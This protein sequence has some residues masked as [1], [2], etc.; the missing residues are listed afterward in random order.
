VQEMSVFRSPPPTCQGQWKGGTLLHIALHGQF[1]AHPARKL[2][3]DRQAQPRPSLGLRGALIDLG[4][5]TGA[6]L[7][8]IPAGVEITA[9]DITPGMVERI[10]Q[11]ARRLDRA[12][13]A[14]VMD[15][16]ALPLQM[17][18]STRWS[19]T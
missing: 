19:S 10:R 1:A 3:A 13:T 5:G 12:V 14:E 17:R 6:D 16:H 15:G 11:R 7:P 8:F 18:A 9:G 2:A 4:A